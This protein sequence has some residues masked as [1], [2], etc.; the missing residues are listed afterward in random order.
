[1]K[2]YEILLYKH[3]FQRCSSNTSETAQRASRWFRW[4]KYR[5]VCARRKGMLSCY[6]D[7]TFLLIIFVSWFLRYVRIRF[8]RVWV[9]WIIPFDCVVHFWV[10]FD[11]CYVCKDHT[12]YNRVSSLVSASFWFDIN[13]RSKCLIWKFFLHSLGCH[14]SVLMGEFASWNIGICCE[15]GLKFMRFDEILFVDFLLCDQHR[16]GL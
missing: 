10:H 2:L 1:M 3:S 8:F 11:N 16:T 14:D 7:I 5:Y 15:Y 13:K 12:F 6:G 9:V 4:R